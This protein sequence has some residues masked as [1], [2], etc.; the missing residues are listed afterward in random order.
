MDLDHFGLTDMPFRLTPDDRFFFASSEHSRALSHLLFG[1]AQGEGFIVITGEVGAGKTTLV[2]R[3]SVRLGSASYWLATI[4]V[5]Q[6]RNDDVIRLVA[7]GFGLS[8]DGDATTLTIRL[9][10]RL[11]AERA[12]GRRALLIVDEAQC[13]P[14][15]ALEELRLLSNLADRGRALMQ[16]ILLGQPQFR[17]TMASSELDQLRQRVLASYHINPLSRDEIQAYVEHRLRA[18]GWHGQTVFEPEAYP[19][20]FHYTGGV[21]RRIN[22]LCGRVLM[23][24]A[25]EQTP[26]ISAAMVEATAQELDIDLNG[27]VERSAS[28]DLVGVH[29]DLDPM[30]ASTGR[31]FDRLVQL[32]KPH[33]GAR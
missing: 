13:I 30:T 15:R 8:P 19:A 3:L 4:V 2:E 32:I 18:A 7:A 23:H 11:R 9:T 17:S 10:E 21:P 28:P 26:V 1:L 20:I 24:G 29:E 31:V 22:R 5:P 14:L 27:G 33:G 25:L 12:R 16:I 6:S